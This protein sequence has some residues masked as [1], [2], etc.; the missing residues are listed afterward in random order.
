[1]PLTSPRFRREPELIAVAAGQAVLRRGS[2]GRPV[3]LVQMALLDLGHAL[4]IS[5]AST[6]YSPDGRYGAETENAVLAF[7]RSVPALFPDGA[8]GRMTMRALDRSHPKFTH[9]INLHVRVLSN[10]KVPVPLMLSN[11]GRAYAPYGI[12]VRLMSGVS[13]GLSEA[14]QERFSIIDDR[15]CHWEV[16]EGELADLHR[17]GPPFSP[18]D[19]GVFVVSMFENDGQGGC[20]AHAADRPACAVSWIASPWDLAHEL[21]H[22]LLTRSFIPTHTSDTRNLMHP[23]WNHALT[24]PT[25]TEKQLAKI[26]SSRLC[27]PV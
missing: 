3:H 4:P 10:T 6:E 18:S 14:D 7:Q 13:L 15:G 20:G 21:C 2:R 23:T 17:L 5:T 19:V 12:E 22:V 25:L 16:N 27:H 9:R 8:V 24:P 11:T 26:R 1:M